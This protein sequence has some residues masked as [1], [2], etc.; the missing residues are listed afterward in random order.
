MYVYI[1]S[2]GPL[3]EGDIEDY[4]GSGHV[5]CPWHSY[6]FNLSD[7]TNEIGLQVSTE[8]YR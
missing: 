8:S 7:G 1:S 4:K 2:G 6:M 5:M 3:Y